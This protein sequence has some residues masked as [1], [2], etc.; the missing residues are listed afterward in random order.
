VVVEM[1]SL[2]NVEVRLRVG[3]NYPASILSIPRRRRHTNVRLKLSTSIA[4]TSMGRRHTNAR[5]DPSPV[6]TNVGEAS[7]VGPQYANNTILDLVGA[8]FRKATKG[9]S[10]SSSS[11][12]LT[13]YICTHPLLAYE[14]LTHSYTRF[15]IRQIKLVMWGLLQFHITAYIRTRH[16][17][18][19]QID[20]CS[21]AS[22]RNEMLPHRNATNEGA[23]VQA[24]RRIRNTLRCTVNIVLSKAVKDDQILS[25]HFPSHQSLSS[26]ILIVV[27]RY[28]HA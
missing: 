12:P 13:T 11:H 23:H 8:N 21:T 3:C 15:S 14:L 24:R 17:L 5:L 22:K 25:L 26:A 10:T 28:L 2:C 18:N 1:C 16:P 6:S 20:E 27:L 4:D 9:G 7:R 19:L